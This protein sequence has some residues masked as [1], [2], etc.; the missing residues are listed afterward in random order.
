MLFAHSGQEEE[1]KMSKTEPSHFCI[2]KL[3]IEIWSRVL[4]I[5]SKIFGVFIIIVFGIM[6]GI[7]G[8]GPDGTVPIEWRLVGLFL[9]GM[10]IMY[11][12]PN[13]II[14]PHKKIYLMITLFPVVGLGAMLAYDFLV[15]GIDFSLLTEPASIIWVLIMI[16]LF[17]TAPL[18]LILHLKSKQ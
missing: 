18:S 2:D 4:K 15:H 13:E 7:I 11:W 9:L 12:L 10:G 14:L 5:I 16:C 6:Y 8:I 3:N 1:N 17:L